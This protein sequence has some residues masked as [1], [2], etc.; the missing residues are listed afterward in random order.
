MFRASMGIDP[1]YGGTFIVESYTQTVEDGK[2]VMFT[3]TLKPATGTP[4]AWG[5]M[6]QQ[7]P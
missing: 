2:A 5:T 3:A 1:E 6:V 7:N 4:P